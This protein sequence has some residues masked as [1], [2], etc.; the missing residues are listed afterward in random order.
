[1]ATKTLIELVDDLDG[2]PATETVTFAIDGVTY[3]IDLSETNATQLRDDI[4]RWTD[5][6]RR[7]GGRR[8]RSAAASGPASSISA[9]KRTAVRAWAKDNGHHVGDRGRIPQAVVDAYDAAH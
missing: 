4:S 7:T 6:G 1:M 5:R 2:S 8:G 3:Q 9:D